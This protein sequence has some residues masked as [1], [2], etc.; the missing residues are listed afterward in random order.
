MGR[1]PVWHRLGVGAIDQGLSAGTNLLIA[2]VGARALPAAEFGILSVLMLV[3]TISLGATRS[4][5]GEPALM[6]FADPAQ[7]RRAIL[8]GGTLIALPVSCALGVA[9]GLLGGD[10][11]RSCLVLALLMPLMLGQDMGR[12]IAFA[13]R[14]PGGALRLD[15]TWTT[16]EIGLLAFFHLSG[17]TSLT[18]ITLAWAIAGA[19][20]GAQS[21]WRSSRVLPLPSAAWIRHS[22]EYSWRYLGAFVTGVGVAHAS[23][24]LVGVVADVTAVGSI[25]G[26][27]V[28]FGPLN[29]LFFSAIAVLVPEAAA[30]ETSP[31]VQQRRLV[32]ASTCLAALA[33]GITLFALLMPDSFGEGLLGS[34]WPGAQ[35]VLVPMGCAAA[36][37]GISAGADIGLRSAGLVRAVLRLQLFLAP[38]QLI[39]PVGFAAVAGAPG[40]AWAFVAVTAISTSLRWYTYVQ[41]ARQPQSLATTSDDSDPRAS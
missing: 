6:R 39:A 34:S 22:W 36:L 14:Q 13:E 24:L 32:Y 26:A 28:L 41:R 5:V 3:Y 40:Y 30:A 10:G 25:R 2:V 7:W 33:G 29:V 20:G 27:T 16:V 11:G 12:Y 18:T 9:G 1:T 8:G 15:I 19:A 17:R 21:A 31:E 38:M 35:G 23:S 4:L 37:G